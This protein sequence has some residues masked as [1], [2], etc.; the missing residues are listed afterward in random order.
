MAKFGSKF[1]SIELT[2]NLGFT[3]GLFP[4]YPISGF[5][6]GGTF[7]SKAGNGIIFIDISAIPWGV[8]NEHEYDGFFIYEYTLVTSA[9]KVI[10]GYKIWVG[11]DRK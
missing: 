5:T 10:I 2:G 7:G 6:F 4:F 1:S 3:L 8:L 9:F 11:K